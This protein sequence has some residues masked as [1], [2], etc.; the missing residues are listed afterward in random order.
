MTAVDQPG[1]LYPDVIAQNAR[2]H[3]QRPAVIC[4]DEQLSWAEFHRRTNK[5]ANALLDLGLKKGDKVCL[6][7]NS[8]V[9]MF[10]LYWGTIKA[11]GV[12]VPLNVMMARDSL[13]LMVNRSNGRFLF[14]ALDTLSEVD[15][16][17]AQLE[18][19][20]A[21]MLF[22]FGHDGDGWSSAQKLIN[23]ASDEDPDVELSMS[24]SMTIIYSSG[25]TGVPKG[26]EHSHFARLAYPL[27]TGPSMNIDRYSVILATTP[28]Y[29]NGTTITMLPAVFWGATTVLLPKFSS[30]AFLEAVE[31]HRCSHVFMVPTQY[32]AICADPNFQ[33]RDVSSMR[34]LLTGGQAMP[35]TLYDEVTAKFSQA[36]IY[37]IY[38]MTEGFLTMALA[39]DFARGKRGSVGKPIF[40]AD[41]VVIDDAGSILPPGE[42]GELAAWGP[43]L[44]KGYYAE[45]QRTQELIWRGPRGRTYLRSGDVGRIDADGFIYISG[46]VKDMIKS[47][48]INVFACDIEEVFMRHPAV[49]ECAAVGIPDDKWGETPLLLVI[50][51]AGATASQDE[52][53]EWG[54]AHLGKYQ[55]VCRVEF[56]SEFPRATHDKV[57]KRALR[58]PYWQ[59]RERKI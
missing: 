50:P 30:S 11:G 37:E 59:G 9:A 47:G 27:G 53:K 10:E 8:S 15:A 41:V 52:I 24:D 49:Q 55:R 40:G 5:V 42:T 54:N 56:R 16:I 35:S 28:L 33:R 23:A 51:H 25:S 48:G 1:L 4:G 6:F 45:P 26:I 2:F 39:E 38:G 58:D 44:M 7:M 29:T 20:A 13:A 34:V 3:A 18:R 57:L 46:R 22:A 43:N 36:R 17:R 31:R 32:I 19:I 14:A 12:I 21:G